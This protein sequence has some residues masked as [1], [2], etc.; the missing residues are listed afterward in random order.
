MTRRLAR[1]LFMAF[2][3][4]L[5]AAHPGRAG[6]TVRLTSGEWPPLI[7]EGFKYHGALSRIIAESFAMEDIT[8]E[9]GFFPWKRSLELARSGEWDGSVAWYLTRDRAL[10]FYASDPINYTRQV[11]FYRKGRMFDWKAIED[12]SRYTIGVTL[13]Y[14]YGEEFDQLVAHGRIRVEVVASEELNLKKVINGRVD[15]AIINL[16][17]GYYLLRTRFA[18]GVGDLLTTHP[19]PVEQPLAQHVLISRKVAGGGELVEAFNRGLKIL[20]ESGKYE[21]YLME[22]RR[23]EYLQ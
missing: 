6:E 18:P 12:L 1:L 8:V 9:W 2:F 14:S 4:L 13:G 22:S 11:F 21:Q 17:L 10:S 19:K 5:A 3:C 15:A 16:E 23:G 7:S 20:R